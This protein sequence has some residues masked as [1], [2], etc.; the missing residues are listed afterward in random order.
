M[1]YEL[2]SLLIR[3]LAAEV[4]RNGSDFALVIGERALSRLD[5]AA[6]VANGIEFYQPEQRL[7]HM[8]PTALRFRADSHLNA[9]GHE[10]LARFLTPIAAK[11]VRQAQSSRERAGEEVR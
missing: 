4:R 9:Q 7:A 3:E 8:P 6:L 5:R 2:T 1:R 10:F 11:H